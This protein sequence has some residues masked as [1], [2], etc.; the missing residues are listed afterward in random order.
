VF[1]AATCTD[2]AC[3]QNVRGYLVVLLRYFIIPARL[4]EPRDPEGSGSSG[5]RRGRGGDDD[6]DMGIAADEDPR[7]LEYLN[8]VGL[9]AC[10]WA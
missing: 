5:G 2:V 8:E 3:T 7:T 6:V 10:M 4:L 9:H 1:T